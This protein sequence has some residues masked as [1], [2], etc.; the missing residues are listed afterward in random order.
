MEKGD[1]A[2]QG[3]S[4]GKLG[5]ASQRLRNFKKAIEYQELRLKIAQEVGDRAG[6]G[7]S[8]CNL[9]ICLESQGSL[10]KALEC[11]CSS[12]RLFNDVRQNLQGKDEWAISYRDIKNVAYIRSW[13]LMLKQ[14]YVVEALFAV[15]EGR[16][17]ALKDLLNSSHE[18]EAPPTEAK[19]T[20]D[21]LYCLPSNT[22]YMAI[23]EREI[24][25][26]IIENG[27]HVHLRR[28]E[29]NHYNSED[30]A[31]ALLESL[32][33]SVREDI[34]VRSGVQCTDHLLDRKSGGE[35]SKKKNDD[36][37]SQQRH[38]EGN[39]LRTC[40]DVIISPI[41]DLFNGD[42]LIFVPEGPLCLAPYAAFLDSNSKYLSESFRIRVIPSLNILKL[43]KDC[44]PDY[45]KNSGVLLVGD[46]CLEKARDW[47]LNLEQLP[48]AKKEVEM[49]GK[50]LSSAPLTGKKATKDEVLKRLSSVTLVHIAAHG[51][52][53]TGEI[54]LAGNPT[55]PQ[56]D[57]LL[58]MSDVMRVK[59]RARMVV[60]SSC[61]SGRG[62]IK[63]EGVVGIARAFLGA[64][65]RSV[66]VS[67]WA[68]D[69][70][71]TL[72]FMKSFY[73]RLAEGRSASESLN[74]AIKCLRES[75]KFCEVKHWAPF[76]LIGDDVTLDLAKDN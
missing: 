9:G 70:E 49:I 46:P 66:L 60:L 30:F 8:Y 5:N 48:C 20:F 3:R 53:E 26:W 52:M 43:I 67:L 54:F 17:Q 39:P 63:A 34:G 45:H 55:L 25:F 33:H 74:Q 7:N 51:F 23:H 19:L 42:E 75:E 47:G 62:E 64:G 32:I 22:V 12:V 59:L 10:K 44:S 27:K 16:A 13:R 58:R 71:A 1:K 73:S 69:D 72:E 6:E 29:I 37:F 41:K 68:I 57:F 4:Y 76:V 36:T 50:I 31:T 38:F 2:R 21:R 14:G 18:T 65:A 11:Y 24:I 56:E 40:Y 15:D 61:Y 28:K 35:S